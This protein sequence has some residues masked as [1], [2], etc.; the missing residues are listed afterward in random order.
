M[1]RRVSLVRLVLDE[2]H[3]H[4]ANEQDVGIFRVDDV[5]A[6]HLHRADLLRQADGVAI[7]LT[8][9]ARLADALRLLPRRQQRAF[10]SVVRAHGYVTLNREMP[11]NGEC[12]INASRTARDSENSELRHPSEIVN[13]CSGSPD[14]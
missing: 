8:D 7:I 4:A 14:C 1:Q 13:V 5:M 10:E 9:H 6:L 11:N 3:H 12:R 2:L